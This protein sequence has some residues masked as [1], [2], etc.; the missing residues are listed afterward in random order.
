MAYNTEYT[1][2]ETQ[3]AASIPV[4]YS[5]WIQMIMPKYSLYEKIGLIGKGENSPIRKFTELKASP[6]KAIRYSFF[7]HLSGAGVSSASTLKLETAEKPIWA[8]SVVNLIA[9][10]H[11]TELS[12]WDAQNLYWGKD[13]IKEYFGPLLS[14]WA[15]EKRDVDLAQAVYVAP[16]TI[17]ASPTLYGY[18]VAGSATNWDGIQAEHV[19]TVKAVKKIAQ[20]A[21]DFDAKPIEGE[22][23]DD[24]IIGVLLVTNK[25]Y[26]DLQEDSTFKDWTK[27]IYP[28]TEKNPVF[29][30]KPLLIHDVLVMVDTHPGCKL[31]P[32]HLSSLLNQ[33]MLYQD[34]QGA[35]DTW[36]KAQAILL[37]GDSLAYSEAEAPKLIPAPDLSNAGYWPN[38]TI[39]D[40]CGFGR[41]KRLPSTSQDVAD[42]A[43]KNAG[44]FWLHT[45][46]TK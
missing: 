12:K 45:S 4:G 23:F 18:A 32:S 40:M 43:L 42:A 3:L 27:Y 39:E 36:G 14:I 24:G 17:E 2:T 34:A 5:Q 30:S 9:R 6:G 33:S 25:Q 1:L 7:E 21:I 13:I 46:Y 22:Y 20:K 15:A 8:T 37:T 11:M 38:M 28:R 26:S 19:L 10:R 44:V 35:G 16:A 29:K 41:T 31:Y